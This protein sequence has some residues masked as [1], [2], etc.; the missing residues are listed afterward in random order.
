MAPDLPEKLLGIDIDDADARSRQSTI[1]QEEEE[2]RVRVVGFGV[3]GY[4]LAVPVA[5]VRT[6]T[7]RPDDLTSVP[8]TP[9]AIAG[10]T[11]LRGEITAVI[12]PT[13]HFPPKTADAS[14]SKAASDAI[15]EQ[16]APHSPSETAALTAE[17]E[18]LLVFDRGSD[19]QSAAIRVEQVYG[20]DAVPESNV[21]DLTTIDDSDLSGD[22]LEHPL[23]SKLVTKERPE[24]RGD[25]TRGS[26]PT[27]ANAD[28]VGASNAAVIE[29]ADEF[30]AEGDAAVDSALESP[31]AA[32]AD[33]AEDEREADPRTIIEVTPVIDVEKLLLASGSI[34]PSSAELES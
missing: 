17:R 25:R 5:D 18:Q 14:A 24:R 21:F 13:V 31:T 2:D 34:E 23:V 3:G 30:S 8:R 19:D 15:E 9:E 20:V 29:S 32:S 12:D 4:R 7:D 6:T 27:A 10:I 16:N 26:G 28:S 22:A 1:D 33:R 11:D